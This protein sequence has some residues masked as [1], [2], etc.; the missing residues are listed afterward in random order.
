[1]GDFKESAGATVRRTL[2]TAAALFTAALAL[3]LAN[4]ATI[5]HS[6]FFTHLGLDPLAYD[7]WGWRIATGAWLGDRIFYQDPLYP[8]FLGFVYAI[9][10]HDRLAAVVLQAALGALLPVLTWV[11]AERWLGRR[12]ALAGGWIAVFYGPSVY[13]EGL[14]LKTWLEALLMAAALAAISAALAASSRRAWILSGFLIGLGCLVRANFLLLLP[15]LVLWLLL[16]PAAGPPAGRRR[17][18]LAFAAGAALVLAVTAARNRVVGGEWVLTTAQGGQNFYIGNNPLNRNG[19]YEPLPFVAANPK[20]EEEDFAREAERRAGRPLRPTEVSRFWFRQALE[21]IGSHPGDWLRLTGKK[22]RVY[23]GA[24]EVPDNLD[25]YLYR[26]SAPILRWP[27]PGFGVVAPLGLLGAFLLARRPGWPRAVLCVLVV[28]STSVVLFFVFARYRVAMMPALFPLAGWAALVLFDRARSALAREGGLRSVLIPVAGL[29]A[30]FAFV[31]LPVRAPA[32]V[33]SYRVARALG[34]PTQAK[35]TATAHYN[36][37]LA[38][39]TEAQ[40]SDAPEQALRRAETELRE[41]L[42]QDRRFAK[43]YVELGKVLARMGRTA[44]AIETYEASLGVE[45]LLWRTHHSLGLLYRRAGDDVRAEAAFRRASELEPRQAD[46]LVEL[47]KLLAETGRPDD[48][49]RSYRRALA[50]APGSEAARRGLEG[51]AG[52]RRSP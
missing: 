2:L 5:R 42:R 13:Y 12:A 23:W 47:G 36:L 32:G 29:A 20:H 33:W 38:Y 39:A 34:L 43:V 50:V 19:E 51:L 1:M 14:I 17:C 24:Y 45:P 48:A 28:Y 30:A 7:E 11:A 25:Y 27:L 44:E 18:L 26:E 3:R 15:T 22:L 6:P 8:Y 9:F 49:E 37:G 4:V 40:D 21:W 41:A 35:T 46:S 10:G 52:P 16:D 31:N